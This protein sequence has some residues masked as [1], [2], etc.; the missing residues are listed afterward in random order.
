M[1]E[2]AE[3]HFQ[4]GC[5]VAPDFPK[6]LRPGSLARPARLGAQPCGIGELRRPVGMTPGHVV[7]EP[8]SLDEQVE[9]EIE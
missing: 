4:A 6:R 8:S 7:H 3:E 1:T 9:E 2:R 5:D